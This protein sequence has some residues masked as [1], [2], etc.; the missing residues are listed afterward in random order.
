V[1]ELAPTLAEAS[2]L[3]VGRCAPRGT[4]RTEAD[5][6]IS[7]FSFVGESGSK[8]PLAAE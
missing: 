5:L 8:L 3:A 6:V 1:R 7:L 2:L 4:H